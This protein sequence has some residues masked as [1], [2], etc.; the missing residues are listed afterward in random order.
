ME[1]GPI[2]RI[3][4]KE[5]KE[6][7][8]DYDKTKLLLKF[9]MNPPLMKISIH[10]YNNVQ[11]YFY[12]NTFNKDSFIKINKCFLSCESIEEIN[13]TFVYL[14]ENKR[15][16]LNKIS[17]NQFCINFKVYSICKEEEITIHLYKNYNITKDDIINDL[18]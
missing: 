10:D 14:I 9:T 16:T 6:F 4:T 8:L 2:S 1:P 18:I 11:N 12:E 13:N 5:E 17:E 7:I 15:Y 3:I